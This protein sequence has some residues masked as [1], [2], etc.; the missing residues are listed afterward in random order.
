M[1]SASDGKSSRLPPSISFR[2]ANEDDLQF[3]CVL[4]A[5]TREDEM[6]QVD[7]SQEQ[8]SAFLEMQFNAQHRFYH[9]QFPE[10][11]YLII[12]CDGEAIGRIYVDRRPDELRLI[13][14]ALLPRARNQGLGKALLMD[15]QDEGQASG[16]P[17]R[18]HVEK[19]NPAMHLYERLGF[20]QVQD[21]GVYHLMEWRPHASE[22]PPAAS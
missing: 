16:L 20:K 10:A 8:K 4:Y 3:L 15:L 14:I 19:F 6:K 7:W 22:T 9:E 18:I 2:S 5:G 21:Q 17:I 1:V 12:E 11:S 13:D